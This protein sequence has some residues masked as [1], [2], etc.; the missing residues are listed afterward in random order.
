MRKKKTAFSRAGRAWLLLLL[1]LPWGLCAGCI[2]DLPLD[3]YSYV[4]NIGIE[5]GDTLPY[6]F[7]FVMNQE[8]GADKASEGETGEKKLMILSA[9]ARTLRE[10]AATLVSAVP[11]QLNFERTS[12]L[13]L[14][15]EL[16]E[17]GDFAGLEDM[18]FG[19]MKLRENMRFV[20]AEG[21]LE[22]VFSGLMSQADPSMSRLKTNVIHYERQ[23]GLTRD[24]T[25]RE[26]LESTQSRVYDAMA[27]YCGINDA[28]PKEDMVG[29]ES[30]PYVG[31]AM[32]VAGELGT[33]IGGTAVFSGKKMVGILSGQ[34][35]MLVRMARG[36]FSRGQL[37]IPWQDD[38]MLT[39]YFYRAGRP[40]LTLEA[41]K[42]VCTIPLEANLEIPLLL[43]GVSS[44]EMTAWL[45]AYLAGEM[46]R[47]FRAVQR[48]NADVFKLGCHMLMGFSSMEKWQAFD[49][50]AACKAVEMTFVPRVTLSHSP[51]KT[52]LE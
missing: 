4:V 22:E 2:E 25:L 27:I 46:Q 24:C 37:R 51:D 38:T 45:E 47:V 52:V 17:E 20:V 3:A 7:V 50:K 13:A 6:R 28:S 31:G 30:Y 1:L 33:T 14:S 8:E 11:S 9:E 16:A 34:H 42:G 43:P 36:E 19:R 12:L 21:R 32:L 40:T 44:R 39:V 10:A 26:L 49:V 23:E 15:R 5:R 35:T 18:A 41:G 29:G 48:E